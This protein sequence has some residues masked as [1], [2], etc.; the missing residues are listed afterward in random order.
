M[1]L[2]SAFLTTVPQAPDF[3]G[4]GSLANAMHIDSTGPASVI[5]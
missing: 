1:I 2:S 4:D 5:P 3:T